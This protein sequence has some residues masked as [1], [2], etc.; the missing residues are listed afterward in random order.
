VYQVQPEDP[1]LYR[2]SLKFGVTYMSIAQ[3]SRLVNPNLIHV[4]DTLIIPGCGTTGYI[5]PATL[6]PS[7]PFGGV[8][9]IPPG[10]GCSGGQ[11]TVVQGD[12][13]FALSLSW[14]TTVAAIASC[15]GIQNVNLIYID[16]VLN[17]PS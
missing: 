15:N 17:I 16:Q 14:N 10:G 1:N 7:P 9:Q 13:L 2:I 11:Y 12:T 3:A 6:T 8:T 4:W 5:P